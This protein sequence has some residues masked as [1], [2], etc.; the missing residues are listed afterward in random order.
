V[1]DPF[2]IQLA[3]VSPELSRRRSLFEV[4][5]VV[6]VLVLAY[7]DGSV[8]LAAWARSASRLVGFGLTLAKAPGVVRRRLETASLQQQR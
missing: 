5:S 4:N 1:P 2:S 8:T 7:L 6:V 3:P